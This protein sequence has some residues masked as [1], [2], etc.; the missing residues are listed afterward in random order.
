MRDLVFVGGGHAHLESL[1]KIENLKHQDVDIKLISPYPYTY[2]SGMGPGILGDIYN[3]EQTRFNVKKII[4]SN[5]G[6]FIQD[7]VNKVDPERQKLTLKSNKEIYYDIVS[8]DIG[9]KIGIK[10]IIVNSDLV[11][12]VKPIANLVKA[13]EKI[14]EKDNFKGFQITIIGRGPAG[15]EVSGNLHRLFNINK[16]DADIQLI[17]DTRLL[18]SHPDKARKLALESL[19]NRGIKVLELK[20][21]I[22][23]EDN[24]ITLNNNMELNSDYT[25]LATGIEPINIFKDSG[26]PLAKDGSILVNSHLQ[27]IK[28]KNVFGGGDCINLKGCNLDKVGVYAVREG[29]LLFYNLLNFVKGKRLK[30][31][32]AQEKYLLILNMGNGKGIGWRGDFTV[33]GKM[34]YLLKKILISVLWINIRFNR[35]FRLNFC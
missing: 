25:F 9:S 10:N 19:T 35:S 3:Q 13:K 12:P 32:K 2:Y 22:K 14:L 28:Y 15:I 6:E 29:P 8:M 31:F 4:E 20:K 27:S 34:I 5:G 7:S 21:V 1:S 26:I 30:E 16:I 23:I 33:K 18:N 24:I 11:I 17:S